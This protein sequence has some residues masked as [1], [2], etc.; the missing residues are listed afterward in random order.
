MEKVLIQQGDVILVEVFSIPKKAKK[1]TLKEKTFVVEQGEGVNTHRVMSE[2][3]EVY[4]EK[5]TLYLKPSKSTVLIH[6]EH[7]T[8]TLE[9][10][11]IYKKI[12]EREFDYEEMEARKTLD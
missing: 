3:L 9:P 6:N 11:K 4:K 10:N 1:I 8:Q 5:E 12:N 2:K 7:N